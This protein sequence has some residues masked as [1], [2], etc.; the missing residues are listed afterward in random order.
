LVNPRWEDYNYEPL[1]GVKN[2]LYWLGDGSTVAD[3]DPN[4]DSAWYLRPENID[5]P[6]G[7]LPFAFYEYLIQKFS[8][9]APSIGI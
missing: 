4:A 3:A 6:P 1:D 5:Y 8:Q 9:A 7:M 2:R